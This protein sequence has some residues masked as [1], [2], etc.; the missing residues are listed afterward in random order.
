LR[1]HSSP[2]A[3]LSSSG[4]ASKADS[5]PGVLSRPL[6]GAHALWGVSGAEGQLGRPC[7]VI[8]A[9]LNA[10]AEVRLP[11]VPCA[12][13]TPLMRSS[14]M[15]SDPVKLRFKTVP[16]V[17]YTSALSARLAWLRLRVP[18]ATVVSPVNVSTPEST[19]LPDP[20]LVR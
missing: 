13:A 8:N 14:S 1:I 12:W 19:K 2:L 15:V 10:A 20:V 4:L 6:V 11:Q 5:L 16:V 7:P 9:R 3:R 18:A 17:R